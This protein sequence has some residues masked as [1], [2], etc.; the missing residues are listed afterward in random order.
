MNKFLAVAM[1]TS[2]CLLA[3]PNSACLLYSDPP[4][5]GDNCFEFSDDYGTRTICNART[6]VANGDTY[7]YD[8][9]LGIWVGPRGYWMNNMYYHGFHPNYINHY[10]GNYHSNG[11][12]HGGIR[13][14]GGHRR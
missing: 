11:W 10:R 2:C 6:Y 4:V 5:Y 9:S 3:V 8:T 13:G 1:I 12:G 7:Y 14:G